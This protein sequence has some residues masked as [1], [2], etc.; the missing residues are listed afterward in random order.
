MPLLAATNLTYSI[1]Q[2][3]ILDRVSIS[4][5]PGERVGL[6]GRNGC[7]KSTL[8]K[9]L[10]GHY[11]PDS[12]EVV[13]QRGARAGYLTQD[14]NLDPERTLREE[15][16]SAFIEL[17]RLHGELEGVY[18]A[19]ASARDDAELE[20]LLARQAEL[21][22]RIEDAGGY[23]VDHKVD[24][25]LHG[26][27]FTDAQFGVKV[28]NLSGGQ[29]GRLALAKLLLEEPDI[30]LLDE[31]TNHLDIAGR[32]W[33]E[34]FLKNE[35]RGA[36]VMVSH[37]RYMLDNVVSRIIEVERPPG[38]GVG[39]RLVEY[40]GN[41]T[42]FTELRY[43]RR[44][45]QLR[46][47][48]NQQTKFR[49]E[50]AFIRRYKAGQ[51]AKQA[52]GRATKLERE[53][54]DNM[55]ERPAELAAMRLELPKAPRSGDLVAVVRGASKA[56]TLRPGDEQEDGA[57][58]GSRKVLFDDLTVT[59]SRG[60]RWAVIGPNGAGKSTLVKAL[61]GQVELDRGSAKLG[62]NVVIGYYSQLPDEPDGELRVYEYL[63]Q[64]VRRENAGVLLSEQAARNLAGSF[65]FSGSEQEKP[66]GVLSGGERSRA[67]LAGLLA[68]AK[69][70][71][72]LDEPTNHLDIMSAERLEEALSLPDEDDP[73]GGGYD[74]TLILI[75][76]DRALIDATC[77]HLIVLDGHGGAEVFH[78]TYTQWHERQVALRKQREQEEAE[79]RRRA[80]QQEK[81]RAEAKQ[82]RGTDGS[83]NGKGK[84]SGGGGLS[85]MPVERLEAEIERLQRR[86]AE[87]DELLHQ[88]EVYRDR[89]RCTALLE[90]RAGVKQEQE[91]YEE[92]WLRRSE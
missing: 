22:R 39:G 54:R 5:E 27:G 21:E 50:E 62:S 86:L 4:V 23:A 60:E 48:E 65:L 26:L 55:L 72:V 3:V 74:G 1:G 38:G 80:E 88:E 79:A 7:G 73:D 77:D 91:R 44:L 12:G 66:M 9:L 52:R 89:E 57:A 81:K 87:I 56:Y 20:R 49:H 84:K 10:A 13:L 19:M 46:A 83:P 90:E 30:L 53:K 17:A 34:D 15:A 16:A 78:G 70:L 71:L 85:W 58:P 92:E 32:E 76:H 37:D 59:I 35:F 41:Y 64:I 40:P 18:E 11:K 8:M 67:R 29:K 42:A 43:E 25:I 75:S 82:A 33:L 28:K 69:N 24:A 63:Q 2:E 51:R 47:Y 36:V 45:A 31:P 68:S 61:L 14:P 6:V